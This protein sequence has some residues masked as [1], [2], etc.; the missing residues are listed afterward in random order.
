[1]K[2]VEFLLS[3]TWSNLGL[4][5]NNCVR[6]IKFIKIWNSFFEKTCTW[7]AAQNRNKAVTNFTK[8]FDLTFH[9]ILFWCGMWMYYVSLL[10]L[11]TLNKPKICEIN[12]KAC[13][14]RRLCKY[15][16]C[17]FWPNCFVKI[18]DFLFLKTK[19]FL[20]T[21]VLHVGEKQEM[22]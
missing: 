19:V 11:L 1:M 12:L 22:F 13:F 8:V 10:N 5:S 14:V 16:L 20:W 17:T 15:A 2:D 21:I 4:K 3:M 9:R 18:F 7:W 6:L